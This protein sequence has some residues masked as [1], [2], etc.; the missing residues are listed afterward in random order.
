MGS[1]C[2]GGVVAVCERDVLVVQYVNQGGGVYAHRRQLEARRS[3]C[4]PTSPPCLFSDVVKSAMPSLP[5]FAPASTSIFGAF[6]SFGAGRKR[7]SRQ[8]LPQAQHL[9][10]MAQPDIPAHDLPQVSTS[11]R[12]V[13]E[14]LFKLVHIYRGARTSFPYWKR[15]RERGRTGGEATAGIGSCGRA[16]GARPCR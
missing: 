3:F 4:L 12:D 7:H 15:R 6:G 5:L 11:R 2:D 14:I 1:G 16:I 8:V 10:P 13:P 9:P